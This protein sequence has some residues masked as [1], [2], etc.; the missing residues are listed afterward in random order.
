MGGGFRLILLQHLHHKL[1][2]AFYSHRLS[3]WPN[4][5]RA[6]WGVACEYA[7]TLPAGGGITPA[8]YR[9]IFL[10]GGAGGEVERGASSVAA[11]ASEGGRRARIGF[12]G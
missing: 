4:T 10:A 9:A 1:V 8:A 7:E 11:I 5:L 12:G 3:K 2:V 6:E